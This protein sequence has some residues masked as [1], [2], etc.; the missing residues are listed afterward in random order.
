MGPVWGFMATE[1]GEINSPDVGRVT[2]IWFAWI[3][4][5]VSQTSSNGPIPRHRSLMAIKDDQ[6][7]TRPFCVYLFDSALPFLP[8]G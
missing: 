8:I 5:P 1:N 7:S 6:D 3:G 2:C 4:L